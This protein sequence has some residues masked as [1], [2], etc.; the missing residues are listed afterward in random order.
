MSENLLLSTG[1]KQKIIDWLSEDIPSFDYGGHVVGNEVKTADLFCKKKALKNNTF[2]CTSTLLSLKILTWIEWY[3]QEGEEIDVDKSESKRIAVAKVT[4]PVNKLLQGER[5]ALNLIARCSGIA[6][7]ARKLAELAKQHG[8]NGLVAGTRKTTPGFRI[9]EKYGML[10]GGIDGHRMDLSS[11]I[12]LKDNHV[13]ATGSIT[14]AVESAKRVGGFSVKIE[15]ECRSLDEAKEAIQAGAD[16]VMLDNFKGKELVSAAAL[17]K[18]YCCSG[19]LSSGRSGVLIEA[20]GGITEN[21]IAEYFS[22][23]VDI[24]SMGNITQDVNHIDFSLKV[25]H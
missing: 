12:M 4:G 15:V 8:Y 17:L 16:I 10:V 18:E 11:M 5:V 1:V 23:S 7:K 14:K 22:D 24:I 19:D 21:N 3:Y 20:S 9:V 2:Y 6:T 13:W 25:T